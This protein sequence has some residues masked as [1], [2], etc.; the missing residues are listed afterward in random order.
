LA[1]ILL[2]VILLT[3]LGLATTA[4]TYRAMIRV[5]SA[6]TTILRGILG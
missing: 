1:G 4:E 6:R 3:I 2:L 5:R